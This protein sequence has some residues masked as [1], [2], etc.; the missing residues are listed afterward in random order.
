MTN[1]RKFAIASTVLIAGA[2]VSSLVMYL[3][4]AD[5]HDAVIE[6][7]FDRVKTIL[8]RKLELVNAK[9]KEGLAPLHW[10]VAFRRRNKNTVELL[11]SKGADV[12]VKGPSGD[13]PLYIAV[14]VH[15][16]N[17]VELLLAEGADVNAKTLRGE[18]A[19][20]RAAL[21]GHKEIAELLIAKGADVD[22]KD[23]RNRTALNI[24]VAKGHK[25]IADLL[26]RYG[27]AE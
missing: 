15:E 17:V 24:A 22:A 27:G 6:G 12:N 16:K 2:I 7:D 1:S 19:L 11:L 25:E 10:A 9:D 3:R 8:A 20:H 23:Y 4:R 26:R 13:T 14:A 5:I 21:E 18:T